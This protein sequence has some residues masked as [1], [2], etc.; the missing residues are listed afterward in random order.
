M[1]LAITIGLIIIAAIAKAIADTLIHHYTTSIFKYK[2]EQF[3]NPYISWQNKYVNGDESQGLKS[4]TILGIR[5][6]VFVPFTDAWHICNSTMLCSLLALPL[7]YQEQL[8]YYL[9]YIAAGII[10]N[11]TFKI[12]YHKLLKK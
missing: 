6:P 1:T 7:F 2:D 9:D 4:T 10:Y 3:W 12:F 11:I 5:I 8:P